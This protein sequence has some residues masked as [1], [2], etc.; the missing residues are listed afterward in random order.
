MAARIIEDIPEHLVV[1]SLGRES[2]TVTS[3][4]LEHPDGARLPDWDPGAHLEIELANGLIRHYSLCGRLEDTSAWTIGVALDPRGR[5]GSRFIHERLVVGDRVR[6]RQLRNHFPFEPAVHQVF[7]AGGIG[8]TPILPMVQ[9]CVDEQ[10]SFS[11][12]YCGQTVDTMAFVSELP[13]RDDVH[14]VVTGPDGY[15]DVEGVLRDLPQGAEIYCCGPEGLIGAVQRRAEAQG[16]PMHFERF[17]APH[18]ELDDT[19]TGVDEEFEVV[20]SSSGA[21][22]SV[23]AGQSIL[24]TL[25]FGG[26]AVDFSCREGTC[27]TCETAVLHGLPDHRDLILS[28]DERANGDTMMICV[29]RSYSPSLTLDL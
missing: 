1:R 28:D 3:V 23:P 7:I 24:E 10:R 19:R 27:G 16:V 25:E 29:S 21:R 12:H 13:T 4:V 11:L 17:S 22:F 14:V 9:R 6:L 26:V 2:D 5:G 8:I 15:L 18:V 20:L